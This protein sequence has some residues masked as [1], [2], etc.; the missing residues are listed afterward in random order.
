[1]PI[2][3]VLIFKIILAIKVDAACDC[4]SDIIITL[5]HES[6]VNLQGNNTGRI[7]RI[8]PTMYN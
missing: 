6:L 4:G 5:C 7:D 8:K 2:S 1:M 3:N